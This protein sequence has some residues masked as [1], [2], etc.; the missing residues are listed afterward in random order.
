MSHTA[1]S[2][3]ANHLPSGVSVAA[4]QVPDACDGVGRFRSGSGGCTLI[5]NA[6]WPERMNI[7]F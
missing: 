1:T 4:D 2:A 6:A 3:V 5:K 7:D